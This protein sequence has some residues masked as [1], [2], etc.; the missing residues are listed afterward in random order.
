MTCQ[1]S[2][3]V[4]GSLAALLM[5]AAAANMDAQVISV[6]RGINPWTGMP[7]RNVAAYNPWSGRVV[8]GSRQ[9]DPWTGATVRRAQVSNPWT[10]RTVTA[11]AV[12]DPWTGQV[13]WNVSGN[14]PGARRRW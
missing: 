2:P 8:H 11:G 12:R 3:L 1:R 5:L 13:H 4:P 14:R 6:N 9:V 10:G 7:Y